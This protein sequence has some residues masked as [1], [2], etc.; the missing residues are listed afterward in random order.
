M[1]SDNAQKLARDDWVQA[2]YSAF[3]DGG[4]QAVKADRL[5]KRLGVTRGS[6]YWHFK[7]VSAL[8]QAVLDKWKLQQTEAVIA[9]N[10]ASGGSAAE[11]LERLLKMCAEDDGAFETGIRAL[12]S[13]DAALASVVTEV[14]T[15][16]TRYVALLLE[17]MGHTPEHAA[18]LSP[19]IYSAWLGEYSR[20]VERTP[21]MRV[22]NMMVLLE[23]VTP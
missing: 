15:L 17:G 22:A 5:A 18:R 16:R 9:A 4:I 8:M 12:V 2:A 13:N 1:E 20:S 21:E 7:N 11:R 19:M 3:E 23:L 6:F 14:D 10:E